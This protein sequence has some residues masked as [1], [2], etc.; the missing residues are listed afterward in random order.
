[1]SKKKKSSS[2]KGLDAFLPIETDLTKDKSSSSN[3]KTKSLSSKEKTSPKQSE[4]QEDINLMQEMLS[5]DASD[6]ETRINEHVEEF[7]DEELEDEEL[8]DEDEL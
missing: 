4:E 3:S 1:M 7:E 8:E 5:D 2:P 6:Y